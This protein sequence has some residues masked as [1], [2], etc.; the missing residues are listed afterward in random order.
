M[1][2]LMPC[3]AGRTLLRIALPLILLVSVALLLSYLDARAADPMD[4]NSYYP[5]LVEYIIASLAVTAAGAFVIELVSRES[6]GAR[7]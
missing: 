2:N 3:K 6:G 4:A 1:Q 5:L 7:K